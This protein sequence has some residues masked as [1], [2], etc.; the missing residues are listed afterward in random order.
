MI[1][2]TYPFKVPQI[3]KHRKKHLRIVEIQRGRYLEEDDTLRLDRPMDTK[4]LYI[5]NFD[6]LKNHRFSG[7]SFD[8]IISKP[9]AFWYGWGRYDKKQS[10]K[11][12]VSRLL[13][14]AG[15]DIVTLVHT[16]L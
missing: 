4:K 8:N 14:R 7:D 5:D 10:P 3:K 16:T 6:R 11:S 1:T 2:Y 13:K 9:R 12:S 15:N